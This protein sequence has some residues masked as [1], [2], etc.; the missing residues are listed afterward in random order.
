MDM[1]QIRSLLSEVQIVVKK[2][3]EMLDRTEW[4]FN[5][6]QL[7]GIGH[8]ENKHSKILAEFLSPYGTHGLG[9]EFL[10]LFRAQQGIDFVVTPSCEVTTELSMDKGRMD[11]V[12]RDKE[13]V[14]VIENKV[15]AGEQEDQLTRYWAWAK[16]KWGEK[17]SRILYLT[18]D[19]KES[20]TA[21]DVP[22]KCVSY[23]EDLLKWISACVRIASER[24]FVRETLRQYRNHIKNLTGKNLED[25]AMFELI[26]ILSEPQNFEA[27]K[28]V[29]KHWLQARDTVARK[30]I[31]KAVKKLDGRCEIDE[32]S[33]WD[34]SGKDK[35]VCVKILNTNASLRMFSLAGAYAEMCVG[36]DDSDLNEKYFRAVCD[37]KSGAS[38]DNNSKWWNRGNC[39]WKYLPDEYQD[40]E[41]NEVLERYLQDE[42]FKQGL[43]NS[44]VDIMKE[45]VEVVQQVK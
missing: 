30:V 16:A 26:D 25:E 6:F 7:C 11:I 27:A 44:I 41:Q 34:F 36:I 23:S 28:Q 18:L 3:R 32:N 13:W 37:A 5:V 15:Y 42:N 8:Y 22:Y 20:E 21:N 35:G 12:I 45:I 10:S 29:W 38:T 19:G 24:P 33:E 17:T 2:N 39:I 43:I 40:W 4:N 9:D 14:V 31:H 1:N